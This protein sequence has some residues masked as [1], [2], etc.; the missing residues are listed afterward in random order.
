V[1]TFYGLNTK[2]NRVRQDI[3]WDQQRIAVASPKTKRHGKGHR[4]NA[5]FSE[6]GGNFLVSAAAVTR[7]VSTTARQLRL[8]A[9]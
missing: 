6:E 7:G 2:R 4:V 3:D 5:V 9:R 8:N 1:S